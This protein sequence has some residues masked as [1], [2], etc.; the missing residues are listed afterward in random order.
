MTHEDAEKLSLLMIKLNSLMDQSVAFV[1]DSDGDELFEKYHLIAGKIMAS[2]YLDIEEPI[3]KKYPEL[4]PVQMNGPYK[5]DPDVY[6]PRF[7]D[8]T[9]P[10]GEED[11]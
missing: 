7:Y 4:R 1:Q 8:P 9:N 3:W 11:Q 2:L 6:Q 10:V 5:I